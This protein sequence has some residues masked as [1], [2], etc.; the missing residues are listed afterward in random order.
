M[1]GTG[2]RSPRLGSGAVPATPNALAPGRSLRIMFLLPFPPDLAGHHGGA[3]ATGAMIEMLSR[4][5]ELSV[6]Y[7]S[8]PGL[9]PP[10]QLPTGCLRL[11]AVPIRASHQTAKS[12]S[13]RLRDTGRLLL[14]GRPGWVEDAWS[15]EMAVAAAALATE[16]DPDAVHFEFHVMSQYIRA[17]REAAPRAVIIV[18]EHEPGISA[19]DCYGGQIGTRRYLAG[20]VRRRAWARFERRTLL[21]ADAV[22]TFTDKDN[23]AISRLIGPGGPH[24]VSIPLR[25]PVLLAASAVQTPVPSD[26]LFIGNFRHPPNV[27]AARRLLKTIFPRVRQALPTATL[28]IVGAD[29]PSELLSAAG[30]GVNVTGWVDDPM[31]Y[32][33]GASVVVA[34]LRQGGGMRVKVLEA[35]AAGK[36][37][38]ASGLAVEG[39]SLN[40]G[41]EFVLA[42]TDDAFVESSLD[43][44]SEFSRRQELGEAARRWAEH[45]LDLDQWAS[46]YESLYSRFMTGPAKDPLSAAGT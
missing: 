37:L 16:V 25:L 21:R 1:K 39:L 3:R 46:D 6:L 22:V 14:G 26:L 13:D 23:A 9:A 18:T 2:H 10:K 8:P 38:I 5:H 4:R 20:L 24:L 43:L 45:T 42:D 15:P 31:P 29:P 36:A 44:L 19:D 33:L 27:D 35:C 7:L 30:D 32:L 41:V 34:P 28:L 40:N 12:L 17:V 11:E